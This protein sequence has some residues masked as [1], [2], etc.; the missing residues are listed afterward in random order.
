MAGGESHDAP[1]GTGEAKQ[2]KGKPLKWSDM[3]SGP[4]LSFLHRE[5][6]LSATERRALVRTRP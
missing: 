2:G 4:T 3:G 6:W 1:H 5:A